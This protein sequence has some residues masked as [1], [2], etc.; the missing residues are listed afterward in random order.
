MFWKKVTSHRHNTQMWKNMQSPLI[1]NLT[2]MTSSKWK[3]NIIFLVENCLSYNISKS[4]RKSVTGKRDN[5]N[6]TKTKI[7]SSKK[8]IFFSLDANMMTL[9]HFLGVRVVWNCISDSCSFQAWEQKRILWMIL[10]AILFWKIAC[11]WANLHYIAHSSTRGHSTLTRAH[12]LIKGRECLKLME[13]VNNGKRNPN[14]AKILNFDLFRAHGRKMLKCSKWPETCSP[15][16]RFGFWAILNFD[17]R[18]SCARGQGLSVCWL[19][20]WSLCVLNLVNLWWTD[21]K[22]QN[23]AWMTSWLSDHTEKLRRSIPHNDKDTVKIW[24]W[25]LILFLR[26]PLN[27]IHTERKKK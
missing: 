26:Y 19:I 14:H 4:G 21:V 16:I 20:T 3:I 23:G 13:I 27:K 9:F 6:W 11:F 8:Y 10:R 12:C 22:R 18:A 15:L 5:L 2:M 17:A 24:R 7:M 1:E 25:L